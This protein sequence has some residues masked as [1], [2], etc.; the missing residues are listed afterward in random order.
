AAG[1]HDTPTVS[2]GG[3]RISGVAPKAYLGNYKALTVPTKD[4]GLDGNSPEIAKAIDQA[5]AD[6][7]NVIN[8]SIGEPEVEPRR[9]IVVK[10]LDNAAAAGVVPVVAAG[11]D[12]QT[13]GL[14]SVGSPANTPA[15][16]TAA[17]STL[18]AK[19]DV[20]APFSSAGPTPVSLLTKPDVTAPGVGVVSSLPPNAFGPLD[21]TS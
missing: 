13:T 15:A 16:I 1:D 12:F 9:D 6:G 3:S 20:I 18:G 8:L 17:A 21:G 4:Y 5:V 19:P 10:A 7:M 11:N 2:G 14:G